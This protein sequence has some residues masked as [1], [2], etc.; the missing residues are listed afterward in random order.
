MKPCTLLDRR[1]RRRYVPT[2]AV[3]SEDVLI[4]PKR[5][6]ATT[7]DSNRCI[8]STTVRNFYTNFLAALL[9]CND[10]ERVHVFRHHSSFH[11]GKLEFGTSLIPGWAKFL[12]LF[13]IK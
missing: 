4:I 1:V 3:D 6:H 13:K 7:E 10:Y 11:F 9:E 12:F 2:V 8:T 5:N